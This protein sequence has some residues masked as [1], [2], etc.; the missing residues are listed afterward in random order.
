LGT[1]VAP[2]RQRVL[3]ASAATGRNGTT[4]TVSQI[5]SERWQLQLL[6]WISHRYIAILYGSLLVKKP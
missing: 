1:R 6:R 3:Q 4:R 2:S 5:P